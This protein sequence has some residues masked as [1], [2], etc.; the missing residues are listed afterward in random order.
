MEA[1]LRQNEAWEYVRN[2]ADP[3]VRLL[4]EVALAK[5]LSFLVGDEEYRSTFQRSPFDLFT[6]ART[7]HELFR[8]AELLQ[9]VLDGTVVSI[10]ELEPFSQV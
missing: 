8:R 10:E 2:I 5:A 9:R 6:Y 7:V 4:T 3:K 1:F